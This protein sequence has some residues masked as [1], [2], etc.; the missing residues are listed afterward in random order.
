M[1]LS[2]HN[3]PPQDDPRRSPAGASP[4][5]GQ[6]EPASDAGAPGFS[7]RSLRHP[8]I[9][10]GWDS[11]PIRRPSG[12]SQPGLPG[13]PHNGVPRPED[14]RWTTWLGAMSRGDEGALGEYFEA[15]RQRAFEKAHGIL[16]DHQL[17]E[18]AVL[19]AYHQVWRSVAQYDPQRGDPLA[20]LLNIVR[21][22]AIDRIR[23]VKTRTEQHSRL[24]DQSSESQVC[25][26][27]GQE[28]QLAERAAELRSC[29]AKLPE[30]QERAVRLAFLEGHSHA[31][32][33]EALGVPLGTVKT[34]IRLGLEKLRQQLSATA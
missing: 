23:K 15:T 14:P 26:P 3:D 11:L 32:I 8:R 17:A 25:E 1:T 16:R 9:A 29:L 12:H 27:P 22:R 33:A 19:D 24:R 4:E 30:D 20:W 10:E 18:E 5:R 31:S 21:S 7:G 28:V 34:R 13:S 2:M 6:R